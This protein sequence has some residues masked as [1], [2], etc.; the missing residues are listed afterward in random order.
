MNFEWV[1]ANASLGG[2]LHHVHNPIAQ[3]LGTAWNHGA[4]LIAQMQSKLDTLSLRP[5]FNTRVTS[6]RAATLRD[7]VQV[8]LAGPKGANQKH[9]GAVLI[10]TGTQRRTL[11]LP[12]EVTHQGR[13]V[14][15]SGRAERDRFH[16]KHVAIVGGGD[17]ALE[18]AL[19]LADVARS[20][21]LIHRSGVFRARDSFVQKVK[22][23]PKVRLL[24]H[25]TLLS[26]QAEPGAPYLTSV[27]LG[28][29]QGKT[30]TLPM[31]G[32]LIRIGVAGQVPEA[33]VGGGFP[34][35]TRGA[36][37]VHVDGYGRTSHPR[38][39]AAGDCCCQAFRSVAVA[40]GQGAQAAYTLSTML[41]S[42][43][44]TH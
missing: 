35:E 43:S 17:A 10:A 38:I 25:S 26:I 5:T 2:T 24:L 30:L 44:R 28:Q 20:V 36:N 4:A 12:E 31:E 32:L 6:L 15:T 21:T 8:D 37:Y 9:Y 18:N 1:E 14:A 34:L 7:P 39:L 29:A 27:T 33:R 22:A 23:H 13:G 41:A 19:L 11:G 3:N 42:L 16:D 40:Q